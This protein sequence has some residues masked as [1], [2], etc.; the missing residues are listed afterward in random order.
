MWKTELALPAEL[1]ESKSTFWSAGRG[2]CEQTGLVALSEMQRVLPRV[3][4]DLPSQLTPQAWLPLHPCNPAL[5]P[6]VLVCSQ[7]PFG[8]WVV[9]IE[10]TKS[11]GKTNKQTKTPPQNKSTMKSGILILTTCLI[12]H[13]I[14]FGGPANF[15][16]L[17][18]F[19]PCSSDQV[20][21]PCVPVKSTFVAVLRTYYCR[22]QDRDIFWDSSIISLLCSRSGSF[23][24][25]QILVTSYHTVL[26]QKITPI[27][28]IREPCCCRLPFPPL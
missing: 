5:P 2:G 23:S 4:S 18:P 10:M 6:G 24:L 13:W 8:R 22:I 21:F 16:F 20:L 19:S 14:C 9:L 1:P 26:A 28:V 17:F 12:L 11:W 3:G 25:L 27:E 7:P 15:S